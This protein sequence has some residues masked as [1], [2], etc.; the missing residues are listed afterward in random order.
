MADIDRTLEIIFQDVPD[1]IREKLPE[2]DPK[3]SR[4]IDVIF[5]Q[6]NKE[7][8]DLPNLQ[9]HIE[10]IERRKME[11]SAEILAEKLISAIPASSN[12][13]PQ[14][15]SSNFTLKSEREKDDWTPAIISTARMLYHKIGYMPE[16]AQVWRTMK[17]DPPIG[18][19][20]RSDGDF[21][22][23]DGESSLSR[24]DFDRRWANLTKSQKRKAP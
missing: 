6:E 15:S 13:Q 2:P 1:W 5:Q 17:N 12:A 24:D 14:V 19:G 7:N 23:M 21:L 9:K 3:L 4:M 20:I 10:S 8:N 11:L 18:Y 16:G 22:V